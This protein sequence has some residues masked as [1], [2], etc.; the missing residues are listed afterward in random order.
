MAV[1]KNPNSQGPSGS[2]VPSSYPGLHPTLHAAKGQVEWSGGKGGVKKSLKA[3]M[4][5][6]LLFYEKIIQ[7][8]PQKLQ[9]PFPDIFSVNVR[10]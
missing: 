6:R 10:R 1:R 7:T 5:G 9:N 8:Q 4:D 3:A 2:R